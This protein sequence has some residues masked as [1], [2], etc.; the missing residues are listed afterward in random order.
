MGSVIGDILPQA[1]GVVISEAVCKG[2]LAPLRE[3]L[4]K[5]YHV[6]IQCSF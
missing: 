5:R 4:D 2:R 1:I 3:G 6:F